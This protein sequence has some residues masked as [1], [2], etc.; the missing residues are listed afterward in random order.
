MVIYIYGY[1]WLYMPIY[2]ILDVCTCILMSGL[3]FGMSGLGFGCLDLFLD[4]W[5]CS[6]LCLDSFLGVCV[7]VGCDYGVRVS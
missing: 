4:V 3:V 7:L 5:T 2:C 6:F 1:I